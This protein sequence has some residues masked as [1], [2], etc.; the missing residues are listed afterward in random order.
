M[1]KE[2]LEKLPATFLDE[3]RVASFTEC[4]FGR[5]SKG[6]SEYPEAY[7]F[8]PLEEAMEECLDC[9]VYSMITYYRLKR[10]KEKLD[11]LAGKES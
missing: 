6:K 3:E 1:Y 8:D 5:V 4:M 10:L 2:L 7:T 9:S 11:E